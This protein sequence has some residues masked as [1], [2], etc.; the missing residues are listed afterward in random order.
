[1]LFSK[2]IC[3]VLMAL[4]MA[5]FTS[6]AADAAGPTLP[7]PIRS[8]KLASAKIDAYRQ[9]GNPDKARECFKQALALAPGHA[10]AAARL[11][12]LDKK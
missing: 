3:I 2:H 4:G 7:L 9:S 1:M 6:S 5:F 10:A 11:K 12:E 8:E